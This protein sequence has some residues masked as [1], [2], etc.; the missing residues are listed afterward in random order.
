M[1]LKIRFLKRPNNVECNSIEDLRI[2]TKKKIDNIEKLKKEVVKE[3]KK[4]EI[5]KDLKYAMYDEIDEIEKIEL[6]LKRLGM[7]KKSIVFK[8]SIILKKHLHRVL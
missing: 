1:T 6:K 2:E 3:F 5:L 8:K 4:L 7:S